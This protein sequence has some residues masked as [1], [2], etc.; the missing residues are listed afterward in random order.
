MNISRTITGS[1]PIP[2]AEAKLYCKAN[3]Y[4]TDDLLISA[5]VTA[6]VHQAEKFCNRSF[7]T[8]TIIFHQTIPSEDLEVVNDFK[9]P[10]PNHIAITEVKV[11][12]VVTTDYKTTGLNHLI[13][14]I[15][16]LGVGDDGRNAQVQITFTA[17]DCNESEK[18]AIKNIVKEKYFNRSDGPLSE[19][20]YAY[21]L[22]FVCYY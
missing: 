2:L 20:A 14:S 8:Q 4:D 18:D 21:L 9:L 11:N 12:G 7:Q 10:Y 3:D 15:S 19:N 17:G 22:P 5:L 6:A 16:G 1:S 13:V